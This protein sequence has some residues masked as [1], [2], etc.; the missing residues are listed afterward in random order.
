MDAQPINM[1][2]AVWLLHAQ[3]I[4]AKGPSDTC[5]NGCNMCRALRRATRTI[6]VGY[7]KPVAVLLRNS[8]GFIKIPVKIEGPLF[9]AAV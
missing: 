1:S 3:N 2:S 5:P 7:E 6:L 9:C 8:L 4:D